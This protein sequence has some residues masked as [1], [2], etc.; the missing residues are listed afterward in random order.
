MSS[1][2]KHH[3]TSESPKQKQTTQLSPT[4]SR[5]TE[6]LEKTSVSTTN[7]GSS[8]SSTRTVQ[9]SSTSRVST[10]KS[11]F[12]DNTTKVSGVQD[13]LNR[14]RNADLGKIIVFIDY[15][16]AFLLAV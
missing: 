13:I 5:L 10:E 4:G 1:S 14:M 12:L 16:S 7:D 2:L 8:V 15:F 11:S 9:T 6:K 3:S